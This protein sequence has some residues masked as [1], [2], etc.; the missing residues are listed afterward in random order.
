MVVGY[1]MPELPMR[2]SMQ[3]HRLARCLVAVGVDEQLA[4]RITIKTA[5]DSVTLARW[6]AFLHVAAEGQATVS[7]T[8]RAIGRGDWYGA[9][10][11]LVALEAVGIVE[12]DS[13]GS[14]DETPSLR[15]WR[16]AAPYRPLYESVA[17][18]FTSLS[19]KGE[20]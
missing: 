4:A 20:S 13:V 11:E 17:S 1:P 6:K 16:L 19:T 18:L 10:W 3:L 7:S 15:A 12:S 14:G 9:R 5:G 8:L 2:L